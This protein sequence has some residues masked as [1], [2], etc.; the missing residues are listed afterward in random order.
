MY[1]KMEL[2]RMMSTAHFVSSIS[3]ICIFML[4]ALVMEVMAKNQESFCNTQVRLF[5][6]TVFL[7]RL[8][9]PGSSIRNICM[10]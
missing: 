8:E 10:Y 6:M 7:P 4:L 1:W 2:F 3:A 5:E 9:I